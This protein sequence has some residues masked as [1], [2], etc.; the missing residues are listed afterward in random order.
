[1]Q[2]VLHSQPLMIQGADE[3]TAAGY[4]DVNRHYSSLIQKVSIINLESSIKYIISLKPDN[5]R[6]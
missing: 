2:L 1:M 4:A 3:D 5:P 6:T